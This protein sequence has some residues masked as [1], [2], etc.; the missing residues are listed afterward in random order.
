M[1]NQI[2]IL[3]GPIRTG[4]TTWLANWVKDKDAGGILTP[5]IEG[6]RHFLDVRT[7]KYWKMEAEELEG[8][9]LKVGRFIFS[10]KSFDRANQLIQ[11]HAIL[12]P[13]ALVIDEIGPL[14]LSGNG[15]SC[16]LDWI[17]ERKWSFPVVLVVREGL[18][19]E[20]LE[21]YDINAEIWKF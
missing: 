2:K 16:C 18:V 11:N 21:R 7:R 6:I 19:E 20:V 5:D 12:N 14:E 8:E 13:E 10:Q 9:V 15:L 17:L 4:K 3:T 1:K